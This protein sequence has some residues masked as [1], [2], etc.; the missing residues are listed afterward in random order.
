MTAATLNRASISDPFRS[1]LQR[2]G[3]IVL[4]DLFTRDQV[5]QLQDDVCA[6]FTQLLPKGDV[7]GREIIGSSYF[8][9]RDAW[10]ASARQMHNL[11]SVLAISASEKVRRVLQAGGLQAPIA[12]IH[13]EMRVDIPQ[14][15]QYMQPWHQ[16]WRSGQGSLNSVTV[17]L[18]LHDVTRRD[19]AI[20]LLP[21]SHLWGLTEIE[22]LS[23][24]RRFVCK[25]ARLDT[26]SGPVAEI[27]QGECVL[28]S[29]MLVHR[30]G[31]NTSSL[32]RVTA[33][34]RYADLED[35]DFR[36]NMYRVPSESE[37]VWP[38]APTTG[39]MKRVYASSAPAQ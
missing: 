15:V 31:S 13:P 39:D 6:L 30:S 10:K 25:D 14:D 16:D 21:G 32:P 34:L 17:W 38:K 9:H 33:Q 23:N 18:P 36:Q 26:A 4:T 29:Q 12:C 2:D 3:Y 24:P 22:E 8:T 35:H 1:D 5:Q 19:G 27:E 37:I 28:F 11:F 20:E 7:Q